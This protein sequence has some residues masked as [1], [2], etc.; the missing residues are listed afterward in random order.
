MIS[1]QFIC[2]IRKTWKGRLN[3]TKSN[4]DKNAAA[5]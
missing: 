1:Y 3:Q 5:A 4:S 2:E